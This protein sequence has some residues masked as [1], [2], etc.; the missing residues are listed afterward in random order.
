VVCYVL[1]VVLKMGWAREKFVSGRGGAWR[2]RAIGLGP[3]LVVTTRAG[4]AS[5]VS[6]GW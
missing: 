2:A 5:D 1:C 6:S 4:F 3:L